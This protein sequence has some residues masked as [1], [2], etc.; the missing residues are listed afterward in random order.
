MKKNFLISFF[1][2]FLL[3]FI[4]VAYAAFNSE[5]TIT[6]EG[7]VEKDTTPPTC[8]AWYLRD[9]D[10]TIQQAYNQNKFTN[11]G[12]N[13]TWTNKNQ[14][15]FIECSDNMPGN[16]G[17]I[18]VTEITDN[19]N[20]KRYF[21]EVKEY[22][23]SI[24]TDSQAISVVLKDAYLN[25]RTCTLPVGGSNPFLDNEAPTITLTPTSYNKFTYSAIDDME[26]KGYM[27]TTTNEEPEID[28][29]NWLEEPAEVTIDNTKAT[30]YY[31]WVKDEV[32]ISHLTIDTYLLTK[33]E[34]TGT[35]LTLKYVDNNGVQINTGY[36]LNGTPVYVTS[37]LLPGYSNL[38]VKNNNTNITPPSTQTISTATEIKSSATA[39]SYTITADSNGGNIPTTTGWTGSGTSATKSVTYNSA[40]GT[41]PTSTKS[42][43][44]FTGWSLLPDDVTS[45]PSGYTRVEYIEST[46]TQYLNTG[47]IPKTNTKI[48]LDL[49]FNGSFKDIS[50][51]SGSNKFIGVSDSNAQVFNVNFGSAPTEYNNL[52]PW[53]NK[54]YQYDGQQAEAI[55]ITDS[56]RT[57]RNTLTIENGR[58][59]YGIVSRTISSKESDQ[60]SPMY[61]FA[62]NNVS[63]NTTNIFTSFNMRVYYMKIYEGNN[64]M[65][66]F[67]PCI[68]D[69]TGKAGLYDL[70]T[71]TFYGNSGTGDFN[72][73]NDIY[74]TSQTIMTSTQNHT[75]YAKYTPNRYTVTADANGG[76]IP[77]TSGWTGTGNS[78]TKQV[79]MD[80]PYGTL[81]TPTRTGYIF[82]GWNGKNIFEPNKFYEVGKDH[83][84]FIDGND[85]ILKT[86]AYQENYT[87]TE[88]SFKTNTQYTLSFDW[89]ILT[90]NNDGLRTGL[91]IVYSDGTT[92]KSTGTLDQRVHGSVGD[93]GHIIITSDSSKN[94]Q[95]IS[96]WGWQY[97][98]SARLSNIQVEEGSTATT[99]EPYYLSDSTNVTVPT[100]HTIKAIWENAIYTISL[101]DQGATTS[102]TSNIYEKYED[103]YYLDSSASS[104]MTTSTNGITVPLKTGYTFGGYYT[105]QNGSGIQYINSNGFITSNASNTNFTN[106]GTLYA[107][108][109]P[110]TYT[111]NFDKNDSSA[112]GTMPGQIMTYGNTTALTPNAYVKTGYSF[113]EWNTAANGTGTSYLDKASVSNLATSGTITLYAQ[114]VQKAKFDTGENVNIKMKTLAGADS[115][116]QYYNDENIT[117]ITRSPSEPSA[118]NKTSEHIVSV[119]D[120]PTPIYMW[121]DDTTGTIYW[122]SEDPNP[123]LNEDTSFM[124]NNLS[125]AASIDVTPFDTSIA[126]NMDYMF[127]NN[128]SLASLDLSNFDTGNVTNMNSMFAWCIS[129]ASLD[130]SNF[131]TSN[132]TDMSYMFDGDYSIIT[133]DVSNF[134]MSSAESISDMFNDMPSL[135]YLTTP[136]SIPSGLETYLPGIFKDNQNNKYYLIDDSTPTSTLLTRAYALLDT[137]ANVNTKLKALA[138]QSNPTVNTVN[139]NIKAIIYANEEP[140]AANKTSSHIISASTSDIPIYAWYDDEV[141]YIWADSGIPDYYDAI[142]LNPNS[143]SLFNSL[144]SLK[145]ME[146][147]FTPV[148]LQDADYMF[149]NCSSLKRISLDMFYWSTVTS[150]TDMF[151]GGT[152]LN[153]VG[154]PLLYSSNS[155][156][157]IVLPGNFYDSNDVT[158]TYNHL[159]NISP[160]DT[161]FYRKL[162]KFDYGYNVNIK[163]KK[164]SGQIACNSTTTNNSSITKILRSDIEPS[165]ENKTSNHLISDPGSTLPIYAW[166]DNGIIYWW[167]AEPNPYLHEYSYEM[168]RNLTS[169]QE[170]DLDTINTSN[171]VE[172]DYMFDGDSSLINIDVSNFDTSNALWAYG[173]FRNC[174]KLTE[175]DLSSFNLMGIYNLND[176]ISGTTGLRT[177][178]TPNA[179]SVYSD[180]SISLPGPFVD[181]NSNIYTEL[182]KT[183]PTS[184]TLTRVLTMLDTGA[185]V[186]IKLKTLAGQ[187]NPTV[188]TVNTNIEQISLSSEEPSA[189]NKTSAHV[190]STSTSEYPIYAWFDNGIIYVWSEGEIYLNPNSESLFNSMR[191][192]MYTGSFS[193]INAELATDVD[194]MFKNCSSLLY[195]FL[196]DFINENVTSTTDMLYGTTALD[197]IITPEV[198][199]TSSSVRIN[200]PTEFTD[201]ND[202]FYTYL[203]NTSPVNTP[204]FKYFAKFDTGTNVNIKMKTLAGATNPTQSSNDK[205]ITSIVRS[206]TEPSAANKTSEHIVSAQD[207]DLPIYMWYDNGTI[208]WWSEDSHPY[209]NEDASYMFYNIW[210]VT[211][212]DV[213]NF[214]TVNTTNMTR[215]FAGSGITSLDL[216]NFNT[217]NVTNMYSM[218]EGCLSL[219]SLDVT[220]FNTRNVTNFSCMF[221]EVE[222]LTSLDLSSFDMSSAQYTTYMV[223][224]DTPGNPNRG[225]N[226][227]V[228]PKVYPSGSGFSINLPGTFKTSN[229]TIYNTLTNSS[230]TSTTLTRAYTMFDT[231]ANVNVKLKALAGAT[232]PT[233]DTEDYNI[234]RISWGSEPSAANKTSEHVI[235][236]STS[237]YPIYA[238]YDNG[239]IYVWSQAGSKNIYYNSNSESL[240]NSLKGITTTNNILSFNT[241][242]IT[243]AD[244]MFKNCSGLTYIGL[245]GYIDKNITS[246]TD[247]LYGTNP[248]SIFTP[249]FYPTS[250]SVEIILPG[251]YVD[252]NSNYYTELDNTSPI[253]TSLTHVFAKFD[254]GANV[255]VAMKTLA[256][257]TNPTYDTANESIIT[258]AKSSTEPSAANKT[259]EHVVSTQD[260]P[261]PIYMWFDSTTG[262]MYWW[263]ID[264]HPYLNE[265]ASS[266]FAN[267]VNAGDIDVS[268]FNTSLTTEMYGMFYNDTSLSSINLSNFDTYNVTGMSSMFEGTN[269]LLSLDLSSFD[270]SSAP[271]TA[272]M[273][274]NSINSSL[275]TIVTPSAYPAGSGFELEL[276]GTFKTS[277]GTIYTHLENTSPTST[278]LTRAYALLDTGANVNVKLKTL[279]GQTNPTV[280]TVNTAINLV[281]KS[282]EEPSAANKTSSHVISASTSDLPIYAWYENNT[283]Y[284]WSEGL[285]Y[286]N[287]NSES[288]FNSMQ[289]LTDTTNFFPISSKFVTDVDYMF[290]NCSSLTSVYLEDYINSGV[291][292]TTKMLYGTTSLNTIY[293]PTFYPSNSNV[294]INLYGSF[295][296]PNESPIIET[297]SSLNNTSPVQATLNRVFTEFD[298]GDNVNVKLK[299]LAGW[300]NPTYDTRDTNVKSIV[301]SQTEPSASNK[302]SEHIIS[303][304]NSDLPIYAWFDST[305][306]TMYWWSIDDYPYLNE[307]SQDMFGHFE[308]ATNIDLTH[309][310][311]SNV[312]DM[313][314]MFLGDYSLTSLDL[315]DFDTRNVTNFG[316]MFAYCYSLTS[317]DLSSFDMTNA[318]VD[319]YMFHYTSIMTLTTPSEFPSDSTVIM[320]LPGGFT[321]TNSN[322]YTELGSTSPT[323]TVLTRKVALLDTGSNVNIKL[324]KLAGQ[325]NPT[326]NTV[327][328]NIVEI[329]RSDEEPS[330]A[331]KT[332]SHVISASTSGYPIYAWF[333]NGTIYVWSEAFDIFLNPNSESLYNSLSSVIDVYMNS[334]STLV[335]D[336]DYMFKNCSSLESLDLSSHYWSNVTSSTDMLY[337]TESLSSIWTPVAYPS[338]SNVR[339]ELPAT[340]I[341]QS[342]GSTYDYLNNTS[343]TAKELVK[344][345]SKFDT[346]S[347]VNAKIKQLAG[348]TGATV[349]DSDSSI[350][351][352]MRSPSEPSSENKTSEH[353]VSSNDSIVPIYMW[354]DSTTGTMYWWSIDEHPY[355]NEDSSYMFGLLTAATSID[356]TPFDTS[357]TTNMSGM[358]AYDISLSSIDLSDLD[359]SNVTNMTGMFAW[360]G[361]LSSIDL[362]DLDTSNVTDMSGMFAN[363]SNISSLDLSS[364]D[365]SST[366]F[367]T[368]MLN[369]LTSLIEL[370]TP[371]TM[372]INATSTT[373]SAIDLPYTMKGTNNVD[374]TTL[375]KTT[376]TSMWLTTNGA[377]TVT[378]NSNGGSVVPVSKLVI[379]GGTYGTLPTPTKSGYVFKGWATSSLPDGYTE[380]EYIESSGTQW[381]DTGVTPTTNT[382]MQYKFRPLA[383]VSSVTMF[384]GNRSSS[385]NIYGLALYSTGRF[386]SYVRYNSGSY[387]TTS[388]NFYNTSTDYN[389]EVGN[390]YIKNLDT[391]ANV[392]T[393]TTQTT[394][395][396]GTIKLNNHGNSTYSK[397]RTYRLKIYDGSTLI[398]DF[399]PCIN[400][401]TNKAG[402][403]DL[404]NDTFYGN[405]GSGNFTAGNEVS[406]NYI[407]SSTVVTKTTNHTL[408]AQWG[409]AVTVTFNPDGGTVSP[410]TKDVIPGETYGTLPTPT[411]TG[412]TF[413][414][415]K[416]TNSNTITAASTVSINSDH[417]L[418]ADY[419]KDVYA[420]T[421]NLD[422]GSVSTANPASYSVDTATITLNNPTKT[423]YAFTGWTGSNGSTPQTTVTIP[424]GSTGAKSYTANWGPNTYTITVNRGSNI[425][426]CSMTGCTNGQPCNYGTQ[427]TIT[428]NKSADYVWTNYQYTN[429][430][431]Y[432]SYRY[433]TVSTYGTPTGFTCSGT[434][435]TLTSTVGTSN[436]TY[437]VTAPAGTGKTQCAHRESNIQRF[438]YGQFKGCFSTGSGSGCNLDSSYWRTNGSYCAWNDYTGNGPSIPVYD[439]NGTGGQNAVE[440]KVNVTDGYA[441]IYIGTNDANLQAYAYQF[442]YSFY[443]Y[444]GSYHDGNTSASGRMSGAGSSKAE[445]FEG[446]YLRWVSSSCP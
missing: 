266:M 113:K 158:S 74:I 312:Q 46:G 214:N 384:L 5:L 204:I 367:A 169:L 77:S 302:T 108:W 92:T 375:T 146:F 299:T 259:S 275:T 32:N 106:N 8:G 398:R 95:Y 419:T 123:Y 97:S 98:G 171:S 185:N 389:L 199:P 303:S 345:Y 216:S 437:N 118:A 135:R 147:W 403:Y 235:S 361:S 143:E 190:I 148:L 157:E 362:S 91:S 94:V 373:L 315:S 71:G 64:L 279:S 366:L 322:T 87:K 285:I 358:F 278:T 310:N 73:S 176:F 50:T 66:E 229:G 228:T 208:Y 151:Y 105:G 191:G 131:D 307:E 396:T 246:A 440:F 202:A 236:A 417:T 82:K 252:N 183:S 124:F 170:L 280:N 119:Q 407:T 11:P 166:Y 288:L 385:T 203:D 159:N 444:D 75:I 324:K 446:P 296:D 301:R 100:S 120:S 241:Q 257:D 102:A 23:T 63:A 104:E 313:Q 88:F 218:F 129:L 286:L 230:P 141:I 293:T 55:H 409:Q 85:I 3:C 370:K 281:I 227:I 430:E 101:N 25:E 388:N 60:I 33:T 103:G 115:P 41:L 27:V 196:N 189:A 268:D 329:N 59:Q 277:N 90:S 251:L 258:F 42:G 122:W 316:G 272:Y 354:F 30:T 138:G 365:M 421:Y 249:R 287:A 52:Y 179:Y 443:L 180:N 61:L 254:T 387:V 374:Y 205:N 248:S 325:T 428:C 283:I 397:I 136:S 168:F 225:L 372:F 331:N 68:N 262:T 2:T 425:T 125:A 162:T 348:N 150:S 323:N 314:L 139:T 344:L 212:I 424:V 194:Y 290:N 221:A 107:H 198:Y 363:C 346:G 9:S 58:I 37:S 245:Y 152:S 291:T 173:M 371:N 114:W 133:L 222:S 195:L 62:L 201:G 270:L 305:T 250:S 76:S 445:A 213:N 121:F 284:I 390:L 376:P 182:D 337:G 260:S 1:T 432:G 380:V 326:V 167:T 184:T 247:M 386:R 211:S 7:L 401:T 357:L 132:V 217:I 47:Y 89:E 408:N 271:S 300:S 242:L 26:V 240:F 153:E 244:Y 400:N 364:F 416:D 56:I 263:S 369:G 393:G 413:N 343:P 410:T 178:I 219:T 67:V 18:N 149:K 36:V 49:S 321:D 255:N 332:S 368:D 295:A 137:G 427:Y 78:A 17:C 57:N 394:V 24:Q 289:G 4:S 164:L 192:L 127:A 96:S 264:P 83:N 109:I 65:R 338:N 276:P 320:D 43:Y 70:V 381:I 54:K 420:I 243:D 405:S 292:S 234:T 155:N 341:D 333:D 273:L 181:T 116:D 436:K 360:D 140:S 207:S 232:N 298:T 14:K 193:P 379:T 422:G 53:V 186:N 306:G 392:V 402:L 128:I 45:L 429:G 318:Q 177:L 39:K 209:L 93:T 69:S 438:S 355:L 442:V 418:T 334:H 188:N 231:G 224:G 311:T 220:S 172:M 28:D 142:Y 110:N 391:G 72:S 80:S 434:T 226:T 412:Y 237:T 399:V 441:S 274:G 415:W 340:F 431:N 81:P 350:I 99:Y 16:Y 261:L 356:V 347:N 21:K 40:Y 406:S 330:A 335:T 433:K 112:T 282:S 126:T 328:T 160:L 187:T 197:T 317:L 175:L 111:V 253:N 411:K 239:T 349:N 165:S 12:T 117:S 206:N 395:N 404:V 353:I 51:Y 210:N 130:V 19:N 10:L 304:Q 38:I 174:N 414:G 383:T 339:I 423:G 13:T 327:N 200:L 294:N 352:F 382:K 44:T 22:T 319:D 223:T 351:R 35:S 297:Y 144:Q 79:T 154:A 48:E 378:F 34:G 6:G 256:G 161:T 435:C 84:V 15:L 29:E 145:I 156:V 309:F 377:V 215:M 269:S 86:I 336:A 265:D 31:I 238:W 342:T 20:N 308:S 267:L 359:T 163:L 134:D 439:N 233:V 426:S